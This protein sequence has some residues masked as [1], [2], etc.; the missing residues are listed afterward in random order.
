MPAN[1]DILLAWGARLETSLATPATDVMSVRLLKTVTIKPSGDPDVP[2][3][4]SAID[5]K[6]Y[7]DPATKL[8]AV[9]SSPIVFISFVYV[10]TVETSVYILATFAI[11][12]LIPANVLMLFVGLICPATVVISAL[13]DAA[14]V[15]SLLIP[16]TVVI[17]LD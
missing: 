2:L 14:L 12:E 3:V 4:A 11:D 16:L 10:A 7:C 8:P 9:R 15:I 6:S 13:T 17:S 1:V 5:P